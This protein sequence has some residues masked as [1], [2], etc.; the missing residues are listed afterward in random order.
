MKNLKIIFLSLFTSVIFFTAVIFIINKLNNTKEI[1]QEPLDIGVLENKNI[2]IYEVKNSIPDEDKDISPKITIDNNSLITKTKD[3]I[4]KIKSPFVCSKSNTI[5]EDMSYL[6]IGQIKMLPDASYIPEDLIN[7][8]SE[9]STTNE[10]CLT[11]ETKNSFESLIK[12]AKEDGYMI[13]ASSGYRSYE[14][15]KNLFNTMLN[16]GQSDA[17]VSVAKPG[18]SEH[19]LGTTVDLTGS[20]IDYKSAASN[21]SGTPEDNWLKKNAYLYGFI[22][23]YPKGK[24]EITGYK[25]EPWHYR[26]I[27]IEKAN[28]LVK[29]NQT[30]TE[31]F[32]NK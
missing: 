5:F 20:S 30:I 29:N 17:L 31:Y 19:Q 14:T 4:K 8:D 16:S 10:I 28:E 13:K 1:A 7:L 6:N 15:Q 9:S 3:N 11:Q 12:K 21:F 22:Q 2:E 26:Y 25:Y 27:G 23:S 18:Y 32:T 24:E